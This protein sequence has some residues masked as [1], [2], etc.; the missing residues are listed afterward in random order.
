M[1]RRREK[2][3][4]NISLYSSSFHFLSFG[5]VKQP[6]TTGRTTSAGAD[7][8]PDRLPSGRPSTTAM[9]AIAKI[10]PSLK[11]IDR[12]EMDLKMAE[13]G[14]VNIPKTTTRVP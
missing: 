14:A 10:D 2:K 11:K 8:L 4:C 13:R 9:A 1:G 6:L 3:K 12:M 5:L 7:S